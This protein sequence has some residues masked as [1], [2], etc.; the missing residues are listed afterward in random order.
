M[1]AEM[2]SSTSVVDQAVCMDSATLQEQIQ[3]LVSLRLL[4][5][6]V[7]AL[8]GESLDKRRRKWRK[9]HKSNVISVPKG[10]AAN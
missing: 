4:G 5:C 1:T 2:S 8:C 9:R 3:R 7:N 6:G 10:E